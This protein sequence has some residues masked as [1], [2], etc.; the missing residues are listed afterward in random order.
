M[1]E[2]LETLATQIVHAARVTPEDTMAMRKLVWE[3]GSVG[4]AEAEVIF[5]INNAAQKNCPQW[6]DFFVEAIAVYLVD[7]SEPR[8]Y[9]DQDKADWFI[10]Q[11][12]K[13]GVLSTRSELLLL[14]AI[15]ERA[16]HVAETLR[17]YALAQ[18]EKIVL[19]GEGPT[20]AGAAPRAGVVEEGE[21]ALLR[22]V[23]FAPASEGGTTISQD[24]ARALFR[25]KDATRHAS[26][27]AGW[28]PLFVQLVG[29]YLMVPPGAAPLSAARAAELEAFMNDAMPSVGGFLARLETAF[30]RPAT[31]LHAVQQG[32]SETQ[33]A[34][35]V[36]E[37]TVEEANWLKAQ[38]IA[39]GEIDAA[40]KALLAFIIDESGPLPV[41]IDQPVALSA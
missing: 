6:V 30:L 31:V 24:E 3:E 36:P 37:M 34:D 21:V 27:A 1:N 29:N 5:R 22:R 12:G 8:G 4:A 18:V 25:I 35:P 19:T 40:E 11:V 28:Q 23:L 32:V 14:V 41:A 10:A 13:D 33:S 17:A 7:Q 15:F 38:I 2:T 16:E 9:V 39:D 20:R 26:N